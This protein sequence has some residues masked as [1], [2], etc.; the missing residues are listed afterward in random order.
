VQVLVEGAADEVGP[1]LA[2]KAVTAFA[3]ARSVS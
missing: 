2:M 3:V 1:G